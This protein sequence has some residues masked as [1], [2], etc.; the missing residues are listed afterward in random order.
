MKHSTIVM[1]LAVL[2]AGVLG[3]DTLGSAQD[4]SSQIIFYVA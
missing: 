1:V 4:A 2:L 3:L